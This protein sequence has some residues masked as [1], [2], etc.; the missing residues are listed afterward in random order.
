MGVP[1]N[2]VEAPDVI[3]PFRPQ[4]N[5]RAVVEPQP[6]AR[7]V[8]LGDFQPLTAPD[9]LNPVPPHLSADPLQQGGD[10]PVAIPP[11]L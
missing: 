1:L 6:S 3:G 5:A 9:A 11:I 10:P 7:L 2:K 4:A 8:L